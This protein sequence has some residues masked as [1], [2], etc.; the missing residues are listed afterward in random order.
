M[1]VVVAVPLALRAET[2]KN[3]TLMDF[4]CAGKASVKA[5][6]DSHTT[7]CLINCQPSGYGILTQDG[8]FLA[9][10]EAGNTKVEAAL[11]ATKKT[12]HLRVDVEGEKKGDEIAVKSV[13]LD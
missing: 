11:K 13:S 5:N 4:A 2:W 6:P 9:F 7:K 12:N 10:D 3:V 1:L 8:A